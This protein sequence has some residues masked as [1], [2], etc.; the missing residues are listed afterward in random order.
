MDMVT[1]RLTFPLSERIVPASDVSRLLPWI[2]ILFSILCLQP[3]SCLLSIVDLV[4]MQCSMRSCL[5][6][7]RPHIP[8]RSSYLQP[9]RARFRSRFAKFND[10]RGFSTEVLKTILIP[11]VV[12]GGLLITLWTYKCMMMVVFQ[13][14]IIYMPSMPPF[15]RSET[16]EDYA[17]ECRPIEWIEHGIRSVDGTSI[18]LLEGS[19][20]STVAEADAKHVVVLYFQG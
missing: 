19:T 12:F 15:S 2:P 4:S 18:K 7:S 16:I 11:P 6:R 9:R 14:K 5:W 3:Y 10:H 13:N 17:N 8:L 20:S 1:L